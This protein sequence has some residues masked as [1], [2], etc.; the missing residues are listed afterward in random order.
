MSGIQTAPKD[1]PPLLPYV[2]VSALYLFLAFSLRCARGG[3]PDWDSFLDATDLIL[4]GKWLH[5]Y[6]NHESFFSFS[7]PPLP[8][9]L[10]APFRLV[11][12]GLPKGAGD[13]FTA[14]PML[15]GDLLSAWMLVRLVHRFREISQGERLFLSTF[16]LTAWI[17]FFD[18][19]YHS[20]FDSILLFFLFTAIE[21]LQEKRWTVAGVFLAL[22]LLTKQTALIVMI[23]LFF[24]F[25]LGIDRKG[26]RETLG[27]AVLVAF[28]GMAPFLMTDFSDVKSALLDAPNQRPIGYQTIWWIFVGN[29]AAMDWL[30]GAEPFLNTLI[31]LLVVCYSGFMAWRHRIRVEEP[32]FL[33]LCAACALLMVLLE[34]W[35]SLHYFL[36]PFGLLLAWEAASGGWPW[37][38]VLFTAVLSDQFILKY[39]SETHFGFNQ[40]T[41]WIMILLLGGTLAYLTFKLKNKI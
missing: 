22:A 13:A 36:M 18:S 39:S 6:E 12:W 4:R 2:F 1:V 8:F 29:P 24:T 34:G 38:S 26:L 5:L 32:R 10:M 20:H 11:A 21:K 33:G 30:N 7:F 19:A 40:T 16:Y 23:P 25:L 37:V 28:V 35:G 14:V 15:A 17:V 9:F 3:G 31:L 27:T 41:S